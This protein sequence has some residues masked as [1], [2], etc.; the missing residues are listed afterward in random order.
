M[1]VVVPALAGPFRSL[2]IGLKAKPIVVVIFINLN[3]L[4]INV[5][6]GYELLHVHQ[7]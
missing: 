6:V 4:N 3:V 1:V 2:W 7:P 5:T